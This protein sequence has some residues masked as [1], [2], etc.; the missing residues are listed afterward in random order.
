V[1]QAIHSLSRR[2][3]QPFLPVN[4]G[5]VSVTL[6]ESEL[7]GHE[8]GSFTGAERLHRG[9]FERADRGT[10]FLD[11]IAEMPLEL[12]V[13]LLRVL[14]SSAVGRVGGTTTHKVDVRVIAATNRDLPAL[15]DSGGFRQD[16][17]ARLSLWEIRVPSLQRRR[18]DVLLWLERL[19]ASWRAGRGLA[20]APALALD[21][22]AA[23]AL[24]LQTW[25]DNLRGVDRLVHAVGEVAG[26]GRTLALGDLPPWV[27][28]APAPAAAVA[29][30]DARRPA[31]AEAA[32]GVP[33]IPSRDELAAV[34]AQNG[35]SIRATAKHFARDRRQIYRW[36]E[37]FGL[38]GK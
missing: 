23:E 3:E 28:E 20:D 38:K 21:A 14:E 25:P 10:L 32:G 33:A 1:A 26:T 37:A 6:S 18:A 19:L 30:V 27:L 9:Y 24:L 17:H 31:R 5:A 22:Q 36:V 7:F 13:K 35:G 4:C 12:Q 11:E 8:R 2:R 34:L 16:L 29:P 15:V